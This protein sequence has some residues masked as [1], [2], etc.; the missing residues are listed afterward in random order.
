MGNNSSS[1]IFHTGRQG[2][3]QSSGSAALESANPPV[4]ALRVKNQE[5]PKLMVVALVGN[6]EKQQE[7][8]RW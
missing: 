4:K 5:M 1:P 8:D 2:R 3:W 7:L 6:P